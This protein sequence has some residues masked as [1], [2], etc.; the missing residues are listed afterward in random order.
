MR[1][2]KARI[3]LGFA[4]GML[5]NIPKTIVCR[6]FTKRGISKLKCSDLLGGM[7]LP[8]SKV[9]KKEG[10]IFSIIADFLVAGF[11]GISYML[12]LNYTGKNNRII[13]GWLAGLLDFVL[14]NLFVARHG[15]GKVYTNDL[16]TNLIMSLNSSIWGV[17]TA[18][19]AKQL[20]KTKVFKPI[21][22]ITSNAIEERPTNPEY[23]NRSTVKEYNTEGKI[24]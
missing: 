12:L 7:F 23:L 8:F 15:K 16:K 4:A 10:Q 13:K 5:G 21:T 9:K 1:K 17:S 22:H 2:A 18:L 20:E 24:L 11:N 3:I 14:Y 19:I 6:A